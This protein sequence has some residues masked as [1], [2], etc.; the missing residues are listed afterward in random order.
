[1]V[2]VRDVRLRES[3]SSPIFLSLLS[4]VRGKE[5]KVRQK[6]MRGIYGYREKKSRLLNLL[7]G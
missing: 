2:V 6:E 1:M 7:L 4:S 3:L 5:E